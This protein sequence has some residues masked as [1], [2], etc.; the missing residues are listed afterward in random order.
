MPPQTKIPPEFGFSVHTPPDDR[1][2]A[3]R[4]REMFEQ[5]IQTFLEGMTY[6]PSAV[7]CLKLARSYEQIDAYAEACNW[8]LSVVDPSDNFTAW[9]TA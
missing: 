1:R 3:Y 2:D 9:Q 5:T 6:P 4:K 7:L 8:T